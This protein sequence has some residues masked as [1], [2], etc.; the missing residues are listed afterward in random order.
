[1]TR[2]TR[3]T[4]CALAIV[5]AVVVLSAIVDLRSPDDFDHDPGCHVDWFGVVPIGGYCGFP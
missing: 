4:L 1:M 3:W 5:L 2:R